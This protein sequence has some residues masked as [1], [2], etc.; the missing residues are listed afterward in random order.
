[1]AILYY[2]FIII[3]YGMCDFFFFFYHAVTEAQGKELVRCTQLVWSTA[4]IYVLPTLIMSFLSSTKRHTVGQGDAFLMNVGN[5][6][7]C[8]CLQNI[9]PLQI[10]RGLGLLEWRKGKGQTKSSPTECSE[11]L[12]VKDL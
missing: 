2:S 9:Q 3:C 1:M 6:R 11:E 10:G 7:R 5:P 8:L 4:K 12:R